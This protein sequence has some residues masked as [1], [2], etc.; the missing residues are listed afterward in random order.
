MADPGCELLSKKQVKFIKNRCRRHGVKADQIDDCLQDMALK[1]L[2][3]DRNNAV[4][5]S[6]SIDNHIT[7]QIRKEIRYQELLDELTRN[8]QDVIVYSFYLQIDIDSLISSLSSIQQQICRLISIG[9]THKEISQK[10]EISR[11]TIGRE[12][13]LVKRQFA[14]FNF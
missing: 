1:L 3:S 8:F 10:L 2:Q 7:S 9:F 4:L 5:K 14:H 12:I 11:R 6:K 13:S